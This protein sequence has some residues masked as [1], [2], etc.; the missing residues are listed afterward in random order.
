MTSGSPRVDSCLFSRIREPKKSPQTRFLSTAL[1]EK[2]CVGRVRA[3]SLVG[4][5]ERTEKRFERRFVPRRHF[6][7][8]EYPPEVRAVIPI[9]EQ[10]DIPTPSEL[11]E[12]RQQ[13]AGPL[14]K[15]EP[16]QLLVRDIRAVPADH[17]PN[18]QLGQLVVAQVHGLVSAS[19][20][21]VA[22]TP[23]IRFRVGRNPDEDVRGLTSAQA[24]VELGDHSPADRAAELT[25]R[26]APLRDGDGEQRLPCFAH[27]G[28]FGDEA[29][30][31]EIHVRAA[32]DRGQAR[33]PSCRF[34]R[35]TG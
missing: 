22:E 25:E 23:G 26:A 27:V 17:V 21:R 16:A 3:L 11:I 18:V 32:Q 6:E 12:K 10:A 28:A 33:A 19:G 7:P 1:F 4:V 30:P 31:V 34:A 5:S 14:G 20:Q 35:P 29:Q 15:L 2:K 9:V 8:G 24:V 13:R